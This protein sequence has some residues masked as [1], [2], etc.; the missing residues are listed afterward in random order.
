MALPPTV[1]SRVRGLILFLAIV[2]SIALA[3]LLLENGSQELVDWA[4]RS[5]SLSADLGMPK[6]SPEAA[7]KCAASVQTSTGTEQ[8]AMDANRWRQARLVAW[9]M[10][11]GLGFAVALGDAGAV[12]EAQRKE[13]LNGIEPISQT[14]GVPAPSAPPFARS[15]TAIPDYGQWIENDASCTAAFLTHR[16]NPRFGHLYQ[17]GAVIG[18]AAVYRTVCPQCGVLFVPQIRHHA[19]EAGLP[20]EAWKP[21]TELPPD[22]PSADE[23]QKKV[24]VMMEVVERGI[25]G[26]E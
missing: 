2:W 8:Q 10:G 20:E 7:A 11:Y 14:L 1:K 25:M 6:A 24:T 15:V 23:R 26:S 12:D 19:K 17:L 4:F 18:F 3:F 16:Y 21:F 22:D 9:K 5:G 13:S